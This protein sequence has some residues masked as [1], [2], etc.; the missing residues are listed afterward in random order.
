[1]GGKE[2]KMKRQELIKTALGE[3]QPD[4]VLKNGKIINVFTGEILTGDIAIKGNKIA[5]IGSYQARR[6]VDLDGMFVLPGLI[7][8][9]LH[10][11]SSMVTPG[12]YAQEVLRWG[13]TTLITDPHE[14]ANVCG[15]DGIRFMLEASKDL[16]VNYYV[17]LP[18]CVPA[19][20]FEHTGEVFTS[21]KM[22]PFL[23][24]DRV[25]GLAEMM[26]YPGVYSCDEQVMEKLNLFED[27]IID[28][29]APGADGR[30]LQAYAAAGIRTDHESTTYRE[31]RNKLR[32]GISVLV[33]EGSASKNLTDIIDGVL[34]NQI[35]T[36]F[37]AFC[38]DDK[39]L[40]DIGKEGTI[41]HN[42]RLAIKQGMHPVTAIQMATLHPARIYRL[43]DLGAV[44]AGYRA[45]LVVVK[46]LEE[47]DVQAVYKDGQCVFGGDI[48]PQAPQITIPDAISNT[49]HIAPFTKNPFAL[50]DWKT[51]PVIRLVA[52]QIITEKGEIPASEL[53]N[54]FKEGRICKAAVIE[55][56]H[57]TGNIGVGLLEGYGL[58]RGAIA[59]TV[60]HDSHNL[61]VV[62]DND[63]DML[64]AVKEIQRIHGGYAII[65]DGKVF[66]SLPLPVAGLMSE[67][68]A[69]E[70]ICRL[71]HMI[72][73]AYECGVNKGIDPFITLSFI[74]LPVIPQL[75]LTDM[76]VFDVEN[77]TFCQEKK[78]P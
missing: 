6:E 61:I 32:A 45:D 5:G 16:P 58:T 56:H 76:G 24:D 15:G 40:A 74:A 37:M 26:N 8:A 41:A 28:G 62:G 43:W 38:T 57:A 64:A 77:F 67:L 50:P 49:V 29:H 1:M 66:D 34:K 17:Q 21:D 65:R 55:R 20:P 10:V 27:K 12:V 9:H 75:R 78:L 19:T 48:V 42:I 33:R 53:E 71:D 70:L 52:G 59:T 35:D 46:H 2:K 51:L 47:M 63:E 73:A 31:A 36:H 54:A 23:S 44:A 68:P 7:D 3:N 72:A 39:H 69:K 25:T 18:S 13:T 14:I 30:Q 11:E 22:K 60:A 4:L